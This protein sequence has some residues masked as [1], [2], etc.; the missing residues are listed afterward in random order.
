MWNWNGL[1]YWN[2]SWSVRKEDIS[3]YNMG[4]SAIMVTIIS[5]TTSQIFDEVFISFIL[6]PSIFLV[7]KAELQDDN[8]KN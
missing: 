3:G 7:H 2:I 6:I 8:N 5:A 1:V 4:N